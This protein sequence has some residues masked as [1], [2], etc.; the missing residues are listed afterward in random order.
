MEYL[1]DFDD[2]P[3]IMDIDQEIDVVEAMTAMP[4]EYISANRERFMRKVRDLHQ[5]HTG[6]GCFLLT[7]NKESVFLG[8]ADWLRRIDGQL[9]LGLSLVL[10]EDFTITYDDL[11]RACPGM[12]DNLPPTSR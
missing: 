9:G 8:F 1:E 12:V 10:I 11:V 3:T 2:S 5:S 4:M 6:G 7:K